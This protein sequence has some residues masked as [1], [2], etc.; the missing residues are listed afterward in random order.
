MVVLVV[1]VPFV[2]ASEKTVAEHNF[3]DAEEG[4]RRRLL[5]VALDGPIE[6][7]LVGWPNKKTWTIEEGTCSRFMCRDSCRHCFLSSGASHFHLFPNSIFVL[8]PV[9][10]CA[11]DV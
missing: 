2:G 10:S 7:D 6:R 11:G 4:E 9:P 3:R 8:P 1:A 5:P